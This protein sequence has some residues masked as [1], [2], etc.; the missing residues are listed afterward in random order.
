MRDSFD[1]DAIG[2]GKPVADSDFSETLINYLFNPDKPRFLFD[3]LHHFSGAFHRQHLYA[4]VML[5]RVKHM[6]TVFAE[7]VREQSV[8]VL[9]VPESIS[10]GRNAYAIAGK[11]DKRI[12]AGRKDYQPNAAL[13]IRDDKGI[14]STYRLNEVL[15]TTVIKDSIIEPNKNRATARLQAFQTLHP[16]KIAVSPSGMEAALQCMALGPEI[17]NRQTFR[18]EDFEAFWIGVCFLSHVAALEGDVAFSR[19]GNFETF[20]FFQMRYGMIPFRPKADAELVFANGDQVTPHDFLRMVFAHMLEVVPQGFVTDMSSNIAM[21]MIMLE[22]MRTKGWKHPE[23]GG[24]DLKKVNP[25]LMDLPGHHDK[26][27]ADLANQVIAFMDQHNCMRELWKADGLH[28]YGVR[29]ARN[30]KRSQ[31]VPKSVAELQNE[32]LPPVAE[33]LDVTKALQGKRVPLITMQTPYQHNGKFFAPENEP[34]LFAQNAF[35]RSDKRIQA[36]LELATGVEETPKMP[37]ADGQFGDILVLGDRR[38][39]KYAK[40][41]SA[42]HGL[43]VVQEGRGLRSSFEAANFE[44][45]VVDKTKAAIVAAADYCREAYSGVAVM[46]TE[47]TERVYNAFTRN[48]KVIAAPGGNK[49]E[50]MHKVADWQK[51]I[52]RQ[53][54]EALFMENWE[55]SPVLVQLRVYSRLLQFGIVPKA[56]AF[57][58]HV[59]D[60][61]EKNGQFSIES[62]SLVDDIRAMAAYVKEIDFAEEEQ[63]AVLKGLLHSLALADIYYS[64]ELNRAAGDGKPLIDVQTIPLDVKAGLEKDRAAFM[65]LRKEIRAILMGPQIQTLDME[66]VSRDMAKIDPTFWR[67]WMDVDGQRRAQPTEGERQG[68]LTTIKGPDAGIPV[69]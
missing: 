58:L 10:N 47:N 6:L 21:R 9:F 54:R 18:D 64:T 35:A 17:S 36:A 60:L 3:D 19:N 8:P 51:R 52:R 33:Q 5:P 65:E 22:E 13:R 53:G 50:A 4:D 24:L 27:F 15:D 28:D 7:R 34:V 67:R 49:I 46:H 39:G 61:V 44:Q 23:W 68:R 48:P 14:L 45:A 42:Q 31:F 38:A 29:R 25:G 30:L 12:R 59:G 66:D 43:A 57:P 2:N 11:Y 55:T 62:R 20:A 56:H 1:L 37:I 26:A 63:P 69:P 32:I 41:W 16:D 40:E